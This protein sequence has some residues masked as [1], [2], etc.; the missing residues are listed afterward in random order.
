MKHIKNHYTI[1]VYPF[2]HALSGKERGRYAQEM[3]ARWRL[4]WSR[5]GSETKGTESDEQKAQAKREAQARALDDTYFFLPYVRQL[6]FPE[7]A[8]LPADDPAQQVSRLEELNHLPLEKF[9]EQINPYSMLRMTYDQEQLKKLHPLKLEYERRNNQGKLVEQFYAPVRICWVDVALLPQ[10]VGFLFLKV[11][12]DEETLAVS[13]LNDFLYYL[14]QVHKST[15]DWQLP[16]WRHTGEK[17]EYE[18]TSRDLVDFLLQGLPEGHRD[19]R[20]ITHT[21]PEWLAQADAL[22]R[23][24]LTERGQVYGQTFR[25]YTYACLDDSP[26]TG[27]SS[28][29][30]SVV[31]TP[32]ANGDES[33]QFKSLMEQTLYELATCTQTTDQDFMPH[34]NGVQQIMEKGHI[35]LWKTWEGMALHDNVVF[36]GARP[37]PFT[38]TVLAHNVESDYFHLYLLTLYQKLRLS[39]LSGE[40]LRRSDDLYQNL[41]E[42]RG[43]WDL[44]MMFRNHYWFTEVTFKPQGTELY[45]R[46]Q[47]GLNVLPLYD[48]VSNGVRELQEYYE[49]KAEHEVV[50]ATRKLQEEMAKNVAAAKLTAEHQVELAKAMNE[51]VLATNKLQEDTTTQ[52]KTIVDIQTKVEMIEVFVVGFYT[53]EL[54]HILISLF[55]EEYHFELWWSTALVL[56]AGLIAGLITWRK[57]QHSDEAASPQ[58]QMQVA[59]ATKGEEK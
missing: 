27:A 47:Q 41:H 3:Q 56:G 10:N 1:L 28:T 18:F 5:L 15:V 16:N 37:T 48:S 29:S 52:L 49:L 39:I 4:W 57:M 54:M 35:A 7:T 42:A 55:E 45:R 12:L 8:L 46:F 33:S 38:C 17:Q 24:S 19:S 51:N 59:A 20:T 44:F 50:E 53:A 21:L 2:F 34:P 26:E 11:Q 13:R 6:L 58:P 23:Y 31:Q 30:T 25:L 43:L 22:P 32:A 9:T 40:L 14:R 36:L